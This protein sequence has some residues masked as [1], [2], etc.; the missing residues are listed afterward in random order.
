MVFLLPEFTSLSDR[1]S[2]AAFVTEARRLGSHAV[3]AS[4]KPEVAEAE[5]GGREARSLSSV[6]PTDRL[7][8]IPR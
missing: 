1:L 7:G 2:G 4:Y 3:I 5:P 6:I 8:D